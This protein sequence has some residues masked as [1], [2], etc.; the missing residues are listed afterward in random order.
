M[1]DV[2]VETAIHSDGL[3]YKSKPSG[4]SFPSRTGDT[5]SCLGCGKHK[6]RSSGLFHTLLGKPTFF[7]SE[8][9]RKETLYPSKTKAA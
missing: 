4:S 8:A 6:A 7:C 9:C 2:L 5:M 3:R 1:L